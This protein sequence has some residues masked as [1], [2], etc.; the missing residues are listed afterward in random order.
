MAIAIKTIPVLEGDVAQRFIE[1]TE[2]DN[3]KATTVIPQDSLKA[4]HR[5]MER[6][7]KVKVKLPL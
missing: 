1:L 5:M 3:R 4:I 7:K 2:N 6:S